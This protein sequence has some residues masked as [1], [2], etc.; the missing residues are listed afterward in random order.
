MNSPV[1][2]RAKDLGAYY[3]PETIADIL[4]DWVVQTG[5]ERLLEPSIGDGALI[6]AALACA[7]RRT[8]AASLRLFGCDVDP[9]AVAGVQNWLGSEHRL[10]LGSFLDIEPQSV[11]PVDGIISNPPFTRN[12]ALPKAMRDDIRRRFLIKGAAGLWVSFILHAIQFLIPGGRLAAVVPSAALFSNYG[13]DALTRICGQFAQVEIRQLADIPLWSNQ[14]AERGVIVLASGYLKGSSLLPAATRWSASGDRLSDADCS[15]PISFRQA[16]MGSKQLGE[17]A[18]I[19]IGAVTGSNKVFLLS[20]DERLAARIGIEDVRLVAAKGRHTKGLQ[21][22]ADELRQLAVQGEATWLLTPRD[23]SKSR[24]GVRARL[25]QIPAG[26]R[27]T[28]I[29]LNKRSPWW[30]VETGAGFDALFT[31]MNDLGP[32][33][34]MTDDDIRCTNTL[35]QIRFK[36]EL[37]LRQKRRGEP[38][39]A[40]C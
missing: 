20:E 37:S 32:R 2:L 18:A 33:I 30:K 19:S 36:P 21:I 17:V 27:R 9:D 11:T 6:R 7:D 26:T 4:A 35:H 1:H 38:T 39:A 34:V 10:H 24:T 25:A 28:A 3:T 31:Y 29:W 12:H 13:R 8:G 40:A 14:A 5:L 23:L 16:L 22:S 15:T